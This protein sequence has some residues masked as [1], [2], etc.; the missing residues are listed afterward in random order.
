MS[1]K[2]EL[3]IRDEESG[4]EIRID[5]SYLS[6]FDSLSSFDDI[7]SFVLSAKNDLGQASEL[8]LLQEQQAVHGAEK[9]SK[10]T[11]KTA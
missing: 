3:V 10:I 2:L 1:I 7:E 9:K 5:K 8:A 4:R 6:S 11:N